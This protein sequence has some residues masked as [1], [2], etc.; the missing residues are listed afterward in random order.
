MKK[1]YLYGVLVGLIV[2]G[3]T[4]RALATLIVQG[5]VNYDGAARK[6]IYDTDR[7]ITWLDYSYRALNQGFYGNWDSHNE[8]ASSLSLD[9]NGT[10]YDDWRL[11]MAVNDSEIF[12][13]AGVEPPGWP[14]SGEYSFGLNNTTSELGHLFYT[15]LGNKAAFSTTGVPQV[16]CGLTNTGE[17][18]YLYSVIY[19]SSTWFWYTPKS[20]PPAMV[21]SFQMFSGFM[22]I[23]DKNS[24]MFY[25][26][27]VHPGKISA[28]PVP[29]PASI[30][31]LSFGLAGAAGLRLLKRLG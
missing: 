21:Y 15:E 18:D 3:V 4:E 5:T 29:E 10:I 17:F 26:I 20:P 9:I 16:G 27:A 6:L 28:E 13:N 12:I 11:P 2:L 7:D 22:S 23:Y 30:L 31:L 14:Y 25:S 24:Y 1:I 8:W 19:F